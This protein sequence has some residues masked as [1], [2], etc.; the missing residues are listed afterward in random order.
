MV[1]SVVVSVSVRVSGSELA[2]A[3]RHCCPVQ[4]SL[5]R[6]WTDGAH[7]QS[8][9]EAPQSPL[10]LA[11]LRVLAGDHV[12]TRGAGVVGHCGCV[13]VGVCGCM[14]VSGD[15]GSVVRSVSD[16]G[17]VVAGSSGGGGTAH[18]SE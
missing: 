14:C 1:L 4:H 12:G 18:V 7:V 11:Q 17:D 5:A 3:R 6:V 8:A 16:L 10:L 9:A 2:E 15:E 13:W